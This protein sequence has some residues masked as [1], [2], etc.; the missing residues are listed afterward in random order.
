MTRRE[1]FKFYQFI[2]AEFYE[3]VVILLRGIVISEAQIAQ[4]GTGHNQLARRVEALN[5]RR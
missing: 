2:R 3:F 1:I 4:H 5:A